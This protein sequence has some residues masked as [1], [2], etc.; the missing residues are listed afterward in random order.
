[1]EEAVEYILQEMFK[2]VGLS[3]APRLVKGKKW[4]MKNSWSESA[5]E[6]FISWLSGRLYADAALRNALMMRPVRLLWSS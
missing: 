1:V 5:Q 4:Y 3:Y 2:R 6:D